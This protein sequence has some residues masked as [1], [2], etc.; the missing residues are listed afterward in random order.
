MHLA[1]LAGANTCIVSD[2]YYYVYKKIKSK[3]REKNI[4][5][6]R[7]NRLKL[8]IDFTQQQQKKKTDFDPILARNTFINLLETSKLILLKR[9]Y[10]LNAD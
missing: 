4:E 2:V 3:R 1:K 6:F 10:T 8:K 9:V 5:Q 7:L